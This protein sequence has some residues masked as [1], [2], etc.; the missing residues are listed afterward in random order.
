MQWARDTR[1]GREGHR[2]GAREVVRVQLQG[3]QGVRFCMEENTHLLFL[4]ALK[5]KEPKK[6]GWLLNEEVAGNVERRSSSG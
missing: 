4:P 3:T 5:L 6:K 2:R 1:G